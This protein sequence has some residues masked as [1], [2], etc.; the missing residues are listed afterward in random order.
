MFAINVAQ[1]CDKPAKTAGKIY[2]VQKPGGQVAFA[3]QPRSER[4]H[5]VSGRFKANGSRQSYRGS[6]NANKWKVEDASPN[7]R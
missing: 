3:V 4:Q 5:W 1:L 2:R 7:G 6:P